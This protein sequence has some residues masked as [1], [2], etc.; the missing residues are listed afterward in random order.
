MQI[1][2]ECQFG[3][4][5]ITAHHRNQSTH[6]HGCEHRPHAT[7]PAHSLTSIDARPR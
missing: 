1:V 4:I 3:G 7:Y 5:L 6:Q 2:V